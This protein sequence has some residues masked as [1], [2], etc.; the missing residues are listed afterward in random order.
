MRHVEDLE[1]PNYQNL[2]LISTKNTDY[3]GIKKKYLP[4][5]LSLRKPAISMEYFSI[6]PVLKTS[7]A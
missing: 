2:M 1:V 3:L 7:V 6:W 5:L 4:L